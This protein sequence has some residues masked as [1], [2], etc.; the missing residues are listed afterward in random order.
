MTTSLTITIA[1]ESGQVE[2]WI[3]LQ[4]ISARV[5]ISRVAWVVFGN[6]QLDGFSWSVVDRMVRLMIRWFSCGFLIRWFS[7]GFL[8]ISA[9]SG[10]SGSQAGGPLYLGN[11]FSQLQ[12]NPTGFCLSFFEAFLWYSSITNCV[13]EI[14]K[15][16]LSAISFQDAIFYDATIKLGLTTFWFLCKYDCTHIRQLGHSCASFR[17]KIMCLTTIQCF[18][19]KL[20][21]NFSSGLEN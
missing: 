11:I 21:F 18:R 2:I 7:G 15:T 6:V 4:I 12:N 5:I 20:R 1:A 16:F 17:F 9:C 8:M 10:V 19:P 13:K 3:W 14:R